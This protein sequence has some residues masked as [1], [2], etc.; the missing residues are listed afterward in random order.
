MLGG[1]RVWFYQI[2]LVAHCWK[3]NSSTSFGKRSRELRISGARQLI[4]GKLK[5][6][7]EW[8]YCRSTT[9]GKIRN[10]N[11]RVFSGDEN[12]TY[13]SGFK[14]FVLYGRWVHYTC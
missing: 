6:F 14:I 1:I 12:S 2:G 4:F 13:L 11:Y 3:Q 5:F 8:R 10:E 9:R 7:A